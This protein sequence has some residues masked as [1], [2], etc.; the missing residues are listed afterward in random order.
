MAPTTTLELTVP[1]NAAFVGGPVNVSVPTLGTTYQ[2]QIPPGLAEGS[3]LRVEVPGSSERQMVGLDAV[4]NARDSSTNWQATLRDEA[5]TYCSCRNEAGIKLTTEQQYVLAMILAGVIGLVVGVVVLTATLDLQDYTQLIAALAILFSLLVLELVI[6]CGGVPL[7]FVSTMLALSVM[8]CY[9]VF[10]LVFLFV[11][12]SGWGSTPHVAWIWGAALCVLPIIHALQIVRQ[13]VRARKKFAEMLNFEGEQKS[14]DEEEN[15]APNRRNEREGKDFPHSL[16]LVKL[17]AQSLPFLCVWIVLIIT[18]GTGTAV[19]AIRHLNSVFCGVGTLVPTFIRDTFMVLPLDN[20]QVEDVRKISKSEAHKS[21]WVL[22]V[23]VTFFAVLAPT[24]EGQALRFISPCSLAVLASSFFVSATVKSSAEAKLPPHP[25]L[26]TGLGSIMMA[27][28]ALGFTILVCCMAEYS[29]RHTRAHAAIAP[30]LS[31]LLGTVVHYTIDTSDASHGARV[32]IAISMSVSAFW[33]GSYVAIGAVLVAVLVFGSLQV[34][35]W[36]QL[37]GEINQGRSEDSEDNHLPQLPWYH[38][39]INPAFYVIGLATCAASFVA[40]DWLNYLSFRTEAPLLRAARTFVLVLAPSTATALANL[41]RARDRHTS[42]DASTCCLYAVAVSALASVCCHGTW[43]LPAVTLT[44]ELCMLAALG[45]VTRKN[46]WKLRQIAVAPRALFFCILVL[47][48]TLSITVLGMRFFPLQGWLIVVLAYVCNS[49]GR[50]HVSRGTI[51]AVSPAD[52]SKQHNGEP[53]ASAIVSGPVLGTLLL[54]F[55][56]CWELF[57]FNLSAGGMDVAPL[58]QLIPYAIVFRSLS[59][60]VGG[61]AAVVENRRQAAGLTEMRFDLALAAF[62]IA[63]LAFPYS[64]E[65]TISGK[66]TMYLHSAVL[67]IAL[68]SGFAIGIAAYR[69]ERHR[70]AEQFRET[71]D[72]DTE[73][74]P[75]DAEQALAKQSKNYHASGIRVELMNVLVAFGCTLIGVAEVALP[76]ALLPA[77]TIATVFARCQRDFAAAAVSTSLLVV[78]AVPHMG[79]VYGLTTPIWIFLCGILIILF[80]IAW[81]MP[82]LLAEENITGLLAGI[83]RL[84]FVGGG[85]VMLGPLTRGWATLAGVLLVTFFYIKSERHGYLRASLATPLLY[86]GAFAMI[87]NGLGVKSYLSVASAITAAVACIGACILRCYRV[88]GEAEDG[89]IHENNTVCGSATPK[90]GNTNW[91]PSLISA[92]RSPQ[93]VSHFLTFCIVLPFGLGGEVGNGI[94]AIIAVVFC[95][96]WALL[97]ATD[98]AISIA[99]VSVIMPSILLCTSLAAC[100]RSGVKQ[101]TSQL[102][103][104]LVVAIYGILLLVLAFKSRRHITDERLNE[105]AATTIAAEGESQPALCGDEV[106]AGEESS[107]SQNG[108]RQLN[109]AILPE[110]EDARPHAPSEEHS[111]FLLQVLPRGEIY[112]MGGFFWLLCAL[113]FWDGWV[114]AAA[115]L[116]IIPMLIFFVVHRSYTQVHEVRAG[117]QEDSI[118]ASLASETLS[119]YIFG[120]AAITVLVCSII[121]KI[122]FGILWPSSTDTSEATGSAVIICALSMPISAILLAM[123]DNAAQSS[124]VQNGQPTQIGTVLDGLNDSM[125]GMHGATEVRKTHILAHFIAYTWSMPFGFAGAHATRGILAP[126]SVFGAIFWCWR[127]KVSVRAKILANAF[128][129]LVF[130][131]GVFLA[132]GGFAAKGSLLINNDQLRHLIPP[133]LLATFGTLAFIVA[134]GEK[135]RVHVNRE[136][137]VG[138]PSDIESIPLDAGKSEAALLLFRAG[139]LCWVVAFAYAFT[140]LIG[141]CFVFLFVTFCSVEQIAH[142]TEVPPQVAISFW[143]TILHITV[144]AIVAGVEGNIT[145]ALTRDFRASFIIVSAVSVVL[146]HGTKFLSSSTKNSALPDNAREQSFAQLPAGE[147]VTNGEE[148]NQDQVISATSFTPF[149]ASLTPPE[150]TQDFIVYICCVTAGLVGS[151]I[152]RGIY[153]CIVLVIGAGWAFRRHQSLMLCGVMPLL[154]FWAGA[155]IHQVVDEDFREFALGAPVFFYGGTELV[156]SF[157]LRKFGRDATIFGAGSPKN[158]ANPAGLLNGPRTLASVLEVSG[159]FTCIVGGIVALFSP[160]RGGGALGLAG[161]LSFVLFLFFGG[162]L[163]VWRGLRLGDASER[164]TSPTRHVLVPTGAAEAMRCEGTPPVVVDTGGIDGLKIGDTV[165]QF[166]NHD[167]TMVSADQLKRLMQQVTSTEGA[168]LG[169]REERGGSEACVLRVATATAQDAE[170]DVQQDSKGRGARMRLGGLFMM[171]MAVWFSIGASDDIWR[172]LMIIFGSLAAIFSGCLAIAWKREIDAA[173]PVAKPATDGPERAQ[174]DTSAGDVEFGSMGRGYPVLLDGGDVDAVETLEERSRWNP[175]RDHSRRLGDAD[176]DGPTENVPPEDG[177]PGEVLAEVACNTTFIGSSPSGLSETKIYV[178]SSGAVTVRFEPRTI[179]MTIQPGDSIEIKFVMPSG[180]AAPK[181]N[182]DNN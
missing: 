53:S 49:I 15:G 2:I 177:V 121:A 97:F 151:S 90:R 141:I 105:V 45:T 111:I 99:L 3:K 179:P 36:R 22:L 134:V 26:P 56:S 63:F 176:E 126:L 44:F 163:L 50:S 11:V 51:D 124:V 80:A 13:E 89:N 29:G 88:R 30:F 172:G 14:D 7:R 174:E 60:R 19:E 120:G 95:V 67:D 94:G 31:L 8:L 54:S 48:I 168:N 135:R 152:S 178:S 161:E 165:Y 59:A 132:H 40:T 34:P 38:Q 125:H 1:R 119:C 144:G 118:E 131:S 21:I 65:A 35:W 109:E 92:L 52:A 107:N 142:L 70:K 167:C 159:W 123:S 103:L 106:H 57:N 175:S 39:S 146:L 23:S 143:V 73:R 28:T 83:L 164:A 9:L 136:K 170:F 122:G 17:L 84:L 12:A 69:N 76:I 169:E 113:V 154:C 160:G 112:R 149:L 20:S 46:F 91:A 117:K 32:V 74:F 24:T 96:V 162:I 127:S 171:N 145:G 10:L 42:T 129:S 100:I 148:F 181:S 139:Y 16:F 104:G 180:L 108:E 71:Q 110:E 37:G 81:P 157:L 25:L 6:E 79:G 64:V 156:A 93:N 86:F 68:L 116:S 114:A 43:K 47:Y 158:W 4:S 18:D 173:I 130:I 128:P 72:E 55:I 66:G 147:I 77:V 102:I 87:F 101:V 75:D 155:S 166:A 140:G 62:A 82:P 137:N 150:H 61:S 133:I 27:L 5:N 98:I 182:D 115:A 41:K 138:A 153:G 58:F 33:T 78:R 85:C